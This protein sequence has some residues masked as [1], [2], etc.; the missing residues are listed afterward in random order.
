MTNLSDGYKLKLVCGAFTYSQ[1]AEYELPKDTII[2]DIVVKKQFANNLPQGRQI[3]DSLD[4]SIDANALRLSG[5]SDVL[6]WIQNYGRDNL[7]HYSGTTDNEFYDLTTNAEYLPNL[8]ILE[9]NGVVEYIGTQIA[10]PTTKITFDKQEIKIEIK[11]TSVQKWLMEKIFAQFWNAEFSINWSVK[12]GSYFGIANP[13]P[14]TVSGTQYRTIVDVYKNYNSKRRVIMNQ[15]HTVV[16]GTTVV[17][18]YHGWFNICKLTD[19]LLLMS[20]IYRYLAK[21]LYW[22]L[23]LI[24]S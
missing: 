13:V 16:D 24:R 3:A 4:F 2:S 23:Q 17:D 21:P 18:S 22:N 6:T 15:M 12:W 8:W 7:I 5:H 9:R 20:Q 19:L 11:T 1:G 14:D 10:N